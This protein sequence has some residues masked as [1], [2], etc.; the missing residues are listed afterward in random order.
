MGKEIVTLEAFGY[1]APR[2]YK[3]IAGKPIS[4]AIEDQIAAAGG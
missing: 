1:V 4:K 3:S 2:V